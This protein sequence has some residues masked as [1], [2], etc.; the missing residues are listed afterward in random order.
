MHRPS[1]LVLAL[2]A[3][4]PDTASAQAD[5]FGFFTRGPYRSEVPR[6]DSLLRYHAGDRH[7]QYQPQQD[8]LD[9]MVSASA[10]RARF[11][12][13][14]TTE[15]GRPMRVVLISSAANIARLDD[16]RTDVARLTEARTTTDADARAIAGRTPVVVFLSYSIHGNEPAGFEAAMWVAYQLIASDEPTT[17]MVLDSVLVIISPSA[18]P[19]GH[20]R[21]AVWSNSIAVGSDEPWASEWAEP[22]TIWGRYSH[23][24]FDM[25]RDLIAQSQAPVR[26]ALAIMRRWNPQVVVDHH[27]TTEQFFFP[28]FAEPTNTNMTENSLAWVETFGRGNAEAFDRFG[29]QYYTRDIFDGHYVGYFDAAPTV[30]GATGMTYETDGGKA[31]KRRRDDG[32]V[33]TFAEGIAH[34]Y[35]ASL[36]TV[37]TAAEHRQQRLIDFYTFFQTATAAARADR[38]KRIVILPDNDP[39]NAARL[40]SLLLGHGIEVGRLTAPYTSSAAHGYF[41]RAAGGSRRTFAPGAIVVDLAQ[42]RGRM[43]RALLEPDAEIAEPFRSRE[44]AKFQRNQR[45]GSANTEGADFYDVTAWSL[46]FTLG[47]DAF[48]TEDAVAPTV[49]PL[50][51]PDS[52]AV[53]ALSAPGSVAGRAR[54]AYVFPNDRQAAT[55]LAFALLDEGF[56]LN[57]STLPLRADGHRYP[58][59]TFVVRTNRNPQTL[60][61]RI[62]TLA[63]ETHVSVTAVQSAFPD[64][65]SVGVGS[66]SVQP[67]FRPRVI[68]AM[69]DG[70]SQTGYGALWHFLE[71]EIRYPFV[72]VPLGSIGGMQ[73]LPDY[74]VFIVPGGSAGAVRRELGDRGVERLIDWVRNGG[75]VIAY[76]GAATFLSADGVELSSV[77]RVGSNGDEEKEEKGDSLPSNEGLTPPLPSPDADTSAVT[78]VPGAIFR[79]ALDRSHWLTLGYERSELA[80]MVRGSTFLE[81]ST[82]GANPVAIVADSSRL[83]GFVWPNTERLVKGT[84]W[85]AVESQ[86]RGN[87][88]LFA[89]DPLF[90]AYWRGTARLLTNAMLFGTGR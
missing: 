62:R 2:V 48:W 80:V 4:L 8:V 59:G 44:L 3:F 57:V 53:R 14:G 90:R 67:V 34:H 76:D 52:D 69:G 20:E 66:E 37:Q 5:T 58:R 38:M 49:E 7:T 81:P 55:E 16:I 35:V 89:G 61:D 65:G 72:P 11:E 63:T 40:A 87:A 21:F 75:V 42:P 68:V 64:S 51:L 18:N 36:A 33:I 6:P 25:N 15:E 41:D 1:L 22:W 28:P 19:D 10:G 32:T 30:G 54:S 17:R 85:A 73:T 74:N 13:I 86:G 47:L 71:T 12:R 29:W 83:S 78:S 88:V 70:T 56:V 50:T 45:R 46:P 79:A 31:L 39:T 60:H 82:T 43:A 23:Y 77:K 26:A 9:R 24:R 27:S 84:T